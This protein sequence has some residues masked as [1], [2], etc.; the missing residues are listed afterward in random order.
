MVPRGCAVLYVPFRNQPLITSTFPTSWGYETPETRKKMDPHAYF[1]RLFDK[2][3]TTDNTP[4]CCVPLALKFR[5]EV[6][7]GE[8]KILEYCQDMAR[9]GG[10]KMAEIMGTEVLG[11][12]DGSFQRCCF[13][14]VRLPLALEELGVDEDG[15]RKVA[16][17]MQ[18]LTPAEHETYIPIKMYAGQFWCRI[19]GQGYLTMEDFEWAART[20]LQLCERAKKGGWR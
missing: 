20:L 16:K 6:C 13:T 2:V 3:S 4:Y 15:G 12:T 18:E 10:A 7:G 5:S 9:R 17:W 14:N 19:S 1:S 8:E 11:G